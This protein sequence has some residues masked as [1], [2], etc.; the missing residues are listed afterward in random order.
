MIIIFQIF[1]LFET[2][3]SSKICNYLRTK[4][5]TKSDFFR[6]L[7]VFTKKLYIFPFCPRSSYVIIFH[8]RKYAIKN[9]SWKILAV[10]PHKL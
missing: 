9:E 8:I 1:F 6:K 10:T 2:E 4:L 7:T 3:T 5:E